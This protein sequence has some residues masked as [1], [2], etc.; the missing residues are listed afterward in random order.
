MTK[1]ATIARMLALL[2]MLAL[3]AAAY[4]ADRIYDQMRR[5]ASQ[6][7]IV[8]PVLWTR[9]GLGLLIVLL[10]MLLALWVIAGSA[11]NP[12]V[13]WVFL[14]VGL[15]LSFYAPLLMSGGIFGFMVPSF[16]NTPLLWNDNVWLVAR[17]LAITGLLGLLLKPPKPAGTN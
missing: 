5:E 1:N 12:L 14:I 8:L 9:N 7:F 15:L 3:I 16:L 2:A 17:I 11:R 4:A 10:A 6:T 13:H